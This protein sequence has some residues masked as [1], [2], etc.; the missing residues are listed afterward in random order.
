MCRH[1]AAE[2]STLPAGSNDKTQGGKSAGSNM[3]IE[4]NTPSVDLNVTHKWTS[5]GWEDI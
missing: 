2:G 1:A 5:I 3:L 4:E